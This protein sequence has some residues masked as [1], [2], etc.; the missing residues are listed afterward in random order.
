MKNDPDLTADIINIR[1]I[2]D[3]FEELEKERDD[4]VLGSPDGEETP[5]PELWE[6]ENPELKEELEKLENI[7]SGLASHNGD[8][9]W[10][11]SWYPQILIAESHFE[12]YARELAE[13]ICQEQLG[14]AQ[15]PLNCI[16]WEKAAL[17]LQSDYSSV[18]IEGTTYFYRS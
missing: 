11:G 4:H 17:E 10:G 3:R 15:W 6:E 16:D 5:A 14:N 13:D 1:D 8:E 2:I 12:D 18:E 7:L 9:K